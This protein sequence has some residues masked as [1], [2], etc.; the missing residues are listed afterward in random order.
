[1]RKRFLNHDGWLKIRARIKKNDGFSLIELISVI[2]ILGIVAG[3][4]APMFD[5]SSTSVTLAAATIETDLRFTQELAMARNPTS[6]TQEV[7]ITFTAGLGDYTITDPANMFTTTRV[8]P[9]GVIVLTA[10]ATTGGKIAFNK[11]GEPEIG[12]SNLTF[13]IGG[14]GEIARITVEIYSG[15]VT[16]AKL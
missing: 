10:P 2:L 14:G 1:M 6:G 9:Q 7:G 3:V 11:Y 5:T 4:V 12:A 16:Y 15:R 13:D 8:L